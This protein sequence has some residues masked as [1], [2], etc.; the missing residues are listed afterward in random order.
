MCLHVISN[1]WFSKIYKR[2]SY[3]RLK[4][5]FLDNKIYHMADDLDL[6]CLPPGSV[7][8]DQWQRWETNMMVTLTEAAIVTSQLIFDIFNS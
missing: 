2:L 4:V 7:T 6:F 1:V 8:A 5:I 3:K